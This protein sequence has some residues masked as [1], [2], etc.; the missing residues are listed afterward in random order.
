MWILVIESKRSRFSLEV[1]LPQA[2]AY[3]LSNPNSEKPSF[4]LVTNGSN[5]T[6]LKLTK[7]GT[8]Q[9]ALSDEF[10]LLNR[11]NDLYTVLSILKRLGNLML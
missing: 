8:P 11:R 10:S 2:L 3:M 6:F 7:Q 9:Y 1:G 4:G 5:F